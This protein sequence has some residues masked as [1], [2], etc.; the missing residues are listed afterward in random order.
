[1]LLS[2]ASCAQLEVRRHPNKKD[3]WGRY[4]L[5]AHAQAMAL[6]APRKGPPSTRPGT[7]ASRLPTLICHPRPP[8]P[9]TVAREAKW[10]RPCPSQTVR[11][12]YKVEPVR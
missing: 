3:F 10:P 12:V 5:S 2:F 8:S 4:T 11:L 7:R 6:E 9:S 1:M